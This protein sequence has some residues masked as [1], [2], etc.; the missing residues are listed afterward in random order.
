MRAHDLVDRASI[1]DVWTALGGGELRHGRGKA[2]WRDGDGD[3]VSLDDDRG[4]WYDHARGTGG[5]MLSLIEIVLGCDRRD[6]LRWLAGHHNVRLDDYRPLTHDER[7][8]YAQR[9]SHAK[10]AAADLAT[11]RRGTLRR[12]RNN[13]NQFHLSENMTSSVARTLLAESGGAGDDEAWGHIFNHALD[14]HR[15]DQVDRE[16]QRLKTATP[17]ELITIRREMES[18]A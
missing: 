7:R 2:F 15:G 11:W 14:D 6:A 9:R 18:A 5:G 17:A 1:T 3:N 13:R 8:R 4:V 10:S 16:I 12:L